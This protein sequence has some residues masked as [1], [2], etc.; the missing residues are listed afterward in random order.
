M[1]TQQIR[2]LVVDDSA[3]VRG[4][5][6]R[7]L[8]SD[9]STTVAATAMHGEAAL[10]VL[11]KQQIDVVVLDVEMPVMDGLATLRAIHADWPDLP[12]IMASS[13]TTAGAETT[14]E[15]LKLGAVGCIAKPRA[16]SVHEAIQQVCRELLPL[17]KGVVPAANVAPS[18]ISL[19]S[20]GPASP[21]R[22]LVVGS[23]TGGPQALT[24]F[25]SALPADFPLP[26]FIVQH[27]PPQFTTLLAKHLAQDT[28]RPAMEAVDR[29]PVVPGTTYVAPGDFHLSLASD[30][31]TTVT[32]LDQ[33]PAEHFCRPSVNP[34]YRSA[35][36]LFGAEVVSVTLTGMGEDGIEGTREL[37]EAG[38]FVIAQDEPSSVVWGM[39]GAVARDG[40]AQA[41]LPLDKIA[42]C[43]LAR[44]G[45]ETP[46]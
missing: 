21:P 43:V 12:V 39:P 42:E 38:A 20:D 7:A 10:I 41:I 22:V 35:A 36:R 9:S 3:V 6:A 37:A 34:L 25:L 31:V 2:V 23:S 32:R 26:T 11:R 29:G 45:Q 46:R 19:R 4:L 28:S 24:R 5:L 44:C 16:S 40:L 18:S 17:V 1:T 30:G 13:H 15:A 27:M 14:L 8:E 33:G